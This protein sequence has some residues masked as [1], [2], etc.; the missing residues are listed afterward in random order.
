MIGKNEAVLPNIGKTGNARRILVVAGEMSGDTLGAAL[1]AD[2]RAAGGTADFFGI[3]GEK[4]RAAGVETLH[5]VREMAVLG[6]SEVIAR[7]GFFRRVWKETVRLLDE[8]RPDAVLLIDYPGFNLRLAGEAHKRGIPVCYYVCPQVWAW[9]RRRI[10]KMA[11]VIDSLWCL[12]PF[13]PKVFEGTGL[14]ATFTGHPLVGPIDAFLATPPSPLPW[15]EGDPAERVAILPGSREMEIR[16]LLPVFLRAAELYRARHP[17]ASFLVSAANERAAGHIARVV[18]ATLPE[19]ARPRYAVAVK[20]MRETVRQARAALACSGTA[21][22]ETGL[23]GCPMLIAY[24]AAWPT[25]FAGRALIRVKWLG[26]G[27]LIADRTVSPEYIQRDATPE[28]L[29]AGLED[30]VPDGPARAAQLAGLAEIRRALSRPADSP[31]AGALLAR[32]VP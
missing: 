7:I 10:P 31:G 14:D 2:Y 23:V 28:A 25:Y 13:E 17:D 4:M 3:G 24:R 16:R 29:A 18:E 22:L 32:I 15:P 21:T 19:A 26:I 30:I 6:L 1:I 20:A 27:N 8:R 5:D 12:F 11:R 9:N